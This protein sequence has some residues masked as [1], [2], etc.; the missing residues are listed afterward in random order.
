MLPI[1]CKCRERA[2]SVPA[3]VPRPIKCALYFLDLPVY[4]RM[5]S[6]HSKWSV[7]HVRVPIVLKGPYQARKSVK[8]ICPAPSVPKLPKNRAPTCRA[9]APGI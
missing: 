1:F 6:R 2:V 7:W 4:W 9:R 5:D 8:T 3:V